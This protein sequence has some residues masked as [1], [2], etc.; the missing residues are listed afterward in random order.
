LDD[1]W[2]DHIHAGLGLEMIRYE[3]D[4]VAYRGV[5]EVECVLRALG[6]RAKLE[7]RK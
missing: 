4:V 2:V 7:K 6:Q 3:F 1:L 5:V